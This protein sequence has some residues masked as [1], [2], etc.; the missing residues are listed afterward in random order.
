MSSD[1]ELLLIV[2]TLLINLCFLLDQG[3]MTLLHWEQRTKCNFILESKS[4]Q[5]EEVWWMGGWLGQAN[6]RV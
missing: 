6:V 3:I 4:P 2:H 1:F 5:R